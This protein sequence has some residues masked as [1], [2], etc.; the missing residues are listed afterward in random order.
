[1]RIRLPFA[2]PARFDS[3]IAFI[4]RTAVVMF[5]QILS[6]LRV[7]LSSPVTPAPRPI[8]PLERRTLFAAPYVTAVSTDNRGEV[9]ITLSE[10]LDASTVNGRSVQLYTP[11]PDGLPA[12]GGDDVKR[13]VRVRWNAG[14]KRITIKTNGLL[15]NTTFWFKVSGKL[16]KDADGEKLDG[17]FIGAGVRS[18]NNIGGGDLLV[19]SKRDQGTRPVARF[20]TDYG[21][22]NVNLFRDLAPITV[23]NFTRYANE[24]AFDGT[25]IHRSM[26]GFVIQGGG[27]KVNKDNEIVD[28]VAHDPIQNEFQSTNTRGRISMAKIPAVDEQGNPVPGGGPNSATNEWFFNL[29][30]NSGNLD[31]QNGGFTAFGEINSTSGLGTIDTIAG[32]GRINAGGA[33]NT[34]PVNDL[35]TVQARGSLD[36]TAD[37]IDIRKI[38][39]V[40]KVSK[41]VV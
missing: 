14:N 13:S 8:E 4:R 22:I 39:I 15:A 25:F 32:K 40:N 16:V 37:V 27:F 34:L 9:T 1:M 21:T 6:G 29:A 28:V 36:P 2:W 18:G 19:V 12:K 17:E 26:P 35:P 20:T 31:N 5:R 33:L 7:A 10:A 41:L 38:A 11:G 30:D 23:A 3:C 24:G